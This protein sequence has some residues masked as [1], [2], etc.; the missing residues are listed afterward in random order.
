MNPQRADRD[1]V[2]ALVRDYLCDQERTVDANRILAGV[3]SR[4]AT[5]AS[6][7]AGAGAFSSRAVRTLARWTAGAAAAVLIIG[8]AWTFRQASARADAV[9]LVR[10]AR[11][12]LGTTPNDRA[13]RIRIDLAPGMAEHSPFLAALATYDCRLWSRSDRFWV[14]AR[15]ADR[16]WVCGRDERRHVWVAPAA[17][18]GLD[19]SPEDVPEPLDE[20]LDLFSFDLEAVLRVLSTDFDVTT[21]GEGAGSDSGVTRIRGTPRSEHPRPRLRSITVEIDERSKIVRQVVLSRVRAGQPVAEVSFTF[22]RAEDQ[23]DPSYQLSSHL[24]RDAP[25]YGPD[26]RFR[27][28]RELVRFF[29]SLLLKGE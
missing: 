18:I 23:P 29:G 7:G 14:E 1:D 25:V 17:E 9:K 13:Y 8:T 11:E 12:A 10:E 5:E 21:P 28:R 19:F 26:Q 27:R 15:Q 2:E 3:R 16:S 20:A 22:D 6:A 4:M 24:D